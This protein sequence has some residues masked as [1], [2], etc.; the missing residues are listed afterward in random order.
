LT[1]LLTALQIVL[2]Q[3]GVW[4]TV[5]YRVDH[6]MRYCRRSRLSAIVPH[7]LHRVISWFTG[8]HIDPHAHI[9]AG[10]KFPHAG[11]IIIGPVQ[12]GTNCDIYQGVTL[13]ASE[14]T[15]GRRSS[16]PD[17]P[18]VGDRAWIGPGAV[19][20]GN[21]AVENDASVGANSLL[22]RDVPTRGVMIG[23]P[24]RLVSRQGSFAQIHYRNMDS[25]DERKLAL[26]ELETGTEGKR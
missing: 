22:V 5:A 16:G 12:M 7:F 8:I 21:V 10:V 15:F 9:G 24:A 23:V 25:D 2:M 3:Q 26:A 11:Q 19:I 13:G 4:A 6:Y 20:A 14:S 18:T 1:G 17:V